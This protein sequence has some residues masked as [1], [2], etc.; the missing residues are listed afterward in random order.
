[1]RDWRP[2]LLAI[3]L[4]LPL[5]AIGA[6]PG[7]TRGAYIGAMPTEYPEWFKESFLDLKADIAEAAAEGRR[8][9]LLFHQD[10]CPYCN[11][12]VERNLAQRDIEATLRTRFD[13]IALNMWGDREVTGLDGRPY[14]EKTF[15]AAMR[16]Q[17]TPTLLFFDEAGQVIL[18]LNGYVPPA[19]FK[20]ALDWVSGRKEGEVAFRDYVAALERADQA[21]GRGLQRQPDFRTLTDLRRRG[22]KPRPLAVFFEQADC[23]DC[24]VLHRRVLIDPAVREAMAGFDLVQLDMWSRQPITTPD[25]RKLPARDW[26][27]ALDVKFAP[28]IVLFDSSGR[29]VIRWESGFRVFHTAGMFDYVKGRHW[30]REP[31]FQRF[32]SARA[33]HIR[34]SGRSVNIWR[35]AD[36]P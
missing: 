27:R 7:Q 20:A 3:L 17:F 26:A 33:E 10:N 11:Q 9:V 32:L 16:V 31:S 4:T 36:E 24:A 25:G 18:R 1:M 28:S 35:Y 34:E 12:L 30:Q 15:A 23:P 13:V 21:A 2:C 8:V 6:A 29:E 22:P 19:R 14:T 5:F